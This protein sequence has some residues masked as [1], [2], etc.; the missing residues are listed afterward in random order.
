MDSIG[1]NIYIYI[2]I[3]IYKYM[4]STDSMGSIDI[5]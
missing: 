5:M 3:C 2:C 1:S 4:D